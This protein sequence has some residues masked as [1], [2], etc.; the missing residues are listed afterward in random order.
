MIAALRE[1]AAD[2]QA[3]DPELDRADELAGRFPGWVGVLSALHRR[4][5]VLERSVEALS[6]KLTHDPHLAASLHEVLSTAA[7]IRSTAAIL[8]END[9]I[10]PEWRLR[11]H[12]NLNEDSLRLAQSST[13]LVNYLDGGDSRRDR[14]ATPQ[15]EVEAMF[16]DQAYHFGALEEGR[17]TP[18]Q[19]VRSRR[20]LTTDAARQIAKQGLELYARDA[21]ALP[22]AEMCRVLEEE[23]LDPPALAT[24]LKTPLPRLFRRLAVLPVELVGTETGLVISDSAGSRLFRKQVP[25]FAIPN[26]G[27]SCALWPVFQALTQPQTPLRR[28]LAHVGRSVAHFDCFAIA[29]PRNPTS[30]AGDLAYVSTMLILPIPHPTQGEVIR[31]GSSCRVCPRRSCPSRREP[32]VLGEEF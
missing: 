14:R 29:A 8:A 12:R 10:E 11:F 19:V 21:A 13:E 30:F 9:E 16:A 28:T 6:D 22:L 31:V 2:T 7:A 15:E 1:A 32:S 26:F 3:A 27:A 4:N 24:R 23:G 17:L 25:G 18:D 20:D 5:A